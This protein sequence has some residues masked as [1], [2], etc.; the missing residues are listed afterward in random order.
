MILFFVDYPHVLSFILDVLSE[1]AVVLVVLCLLTD[2]ISG[3]LP[4]LEGAHDEHHNDHL[5]P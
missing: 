1:T 3:W 5:D 2:F 4:P